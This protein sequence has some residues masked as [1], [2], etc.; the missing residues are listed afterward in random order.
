MPDLPD[1][2]C[3]PVCYA[4]GEAGICGRVSEAIAIAKKEARKPRVWAPNR[5]LAE[6]LSCGCVDI[7]WPIIKALGK[8]ISHVLCGTH[9]WVVYTEPKAP[10]KVRKGNPG[11]EEIPF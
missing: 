11:Q 5:L 3:F 9:G 7:P 1:A 2:L 6:C 4:C 10:R 8:N